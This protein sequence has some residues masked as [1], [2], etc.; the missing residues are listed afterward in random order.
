LELLL[1]IGS[2]MQFAQAVILGGKINLQGFP[3]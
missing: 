1:P 3:N 2:G